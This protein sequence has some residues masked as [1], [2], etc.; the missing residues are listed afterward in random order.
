LHDARGATR[1]EWSVEVVGRGTYGLRPRNFARDK[2]RSMALIAMCMPI[3]PGKKAKWK[4]MAD[5][6]GTE[7]LKSALAASRKNAGVH[8]R[9][10]LQETPGGDFV[11][12]TLEGDD[13]VAGFGKM[14]ADPSMKEFAVWAADVHGMD[15]NAHPAPPK[16]VYDSKG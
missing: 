9:T 4:E 14:M 12:V 2:E 1:E 11:I 3:L 5:K 13:P 10:F 16:L 6:F 8:E 7:P 15:P